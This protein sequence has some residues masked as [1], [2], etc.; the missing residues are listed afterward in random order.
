MDFFEIFVVVI[1][2]VEEFISHD[3]KLIIIRVKLCHPLRLS[4]RHRPDKHGCWLILTIFFFLG[5]WYLMSWYLNVWA[6]FCTILIHGCR[7]RTR[8]AVN[9]IGDA[10]GAG[11][12]EHLSRNDLMSMD[13][14]AREED[15]PMEQFDRYTP[16]PEGTNGVHTSDASLR[17]TNF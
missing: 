1:S 11:I 15:I 17:A 14:T 4:S 13:Y 7:D 9:V 10:Y 5:I 3:Q 6:K 12:V 16:K 2:G 8:T